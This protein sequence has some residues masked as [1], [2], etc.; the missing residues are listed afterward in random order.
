MNKMLTIDG[1]EA[2]MIEVYKEADA[3]IVDM[4]TEVRAKNSF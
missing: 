1:N 2:V 3:N 4:A